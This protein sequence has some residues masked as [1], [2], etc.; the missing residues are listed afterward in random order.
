MTCITGTIRIQAAQETEAKA[1]SVWL[2]AAL[3]DVFDLTSVHRGRDGAWFV[4]GTLRLDP[5]RAD[6]V[7]AVVRS[8]GQM[9]LVPAPKETEEPAPPATD[10]GRASRLARLAGL[11]RPETVPDDGIDRRELHKRLQA[12]KG[13]DHDHRNNDDH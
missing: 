10:Q 6:L 5:A 8:T 9:I 7:E 12:Q 11:S 4:R 3:G 1:L 2:T 13:E